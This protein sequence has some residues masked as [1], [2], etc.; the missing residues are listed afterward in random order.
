[1]IHDAYQ[2]WQRSK[3]FQTLVLRGRTRVSNTALSWLSQAAVELVDK[4]TYESAQET[5]T[6]VIYHFCK[7][8]GMADDDHM[9]TTLSRLV[10]QL[11]QARPSVLDERS[12]YASYTS[13]LES[14]SWQKRQ[15]KAVC[16]LLVDAMSA[17]Q[18]V[19]VIIDRPEMCT[20][21]KSGL[22][23]MLEALQM[24]EGVVVKVFVVAD[25]DETDDAD[26]GD[27]RDAASGSGFEV[28]DEL[29]QQ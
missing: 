3:T 16:T 23:K 17:F 27:W 1:M 5:T 2:R 24:A 21:G 9:H 13:Q 25:G 18:T 19:Y 26:L 20:S 8:E 10:Y 14:V 29:D 12:T 22:A 15:L 6:A 4:L 28:L 11:L 7:Q